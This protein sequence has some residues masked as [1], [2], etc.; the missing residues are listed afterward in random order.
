MGQ[1]VL[2][3]YEVEDAKLKD[4]L[5]ELIKYYL[6]SYSDVE[7]FTYNIEAMLPAAEAIP[8]LQA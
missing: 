5:K 7:G 8:L 6:Q 4:G 1:K 3:I 2:G